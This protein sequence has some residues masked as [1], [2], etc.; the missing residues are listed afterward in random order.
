MDPRFERR[1]RAV[2]RQRQNLENYGVPADVYI[3]N[4]LRISRQG[5]MPNYRKPWRCCRKS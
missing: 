3:D 5:T 1:D 4:T 2:G